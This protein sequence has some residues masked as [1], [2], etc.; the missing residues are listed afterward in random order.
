MPSFEYS[1][2]APA[3]ARAVRATLRTALRSPLAAYS[4]GRLA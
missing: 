2:A 3:T 1:Q 4:A